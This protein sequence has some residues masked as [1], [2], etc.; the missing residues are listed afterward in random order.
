[1][2]LRTSSNEVR[3]GIQEGSKGGDKSCDPCLSR[4]ENRLLV[5]AVANETKKSCGTCG[6]GI[7]RQTTHGG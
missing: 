1:M 5:R 7:A 4:V 3:R 2:R 6:L